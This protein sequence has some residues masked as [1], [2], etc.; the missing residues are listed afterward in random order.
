MVLS[1][2]RMLSIATAAK[3]NRIFLMPPG[4][5]ASIQTGQDVLN[6]AEWIQRLCVSLAV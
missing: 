4:F 6:K 1:I 2:N 5:S 3:A